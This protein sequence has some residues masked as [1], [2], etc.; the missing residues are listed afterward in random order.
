MDRLRL[1]T[2][3]LGQALGGAAGR[4][5]HRDRD[6]LGDQD[7][8]QRV[9]Q[10][11]LANAGAAGNDHHFGDECGPERCL[12]AVG[13]RQPVGLALAAD[14]ASQPVG[15][16]RDQLNR[17]GAIG[18][19]DAHRARGAD[20]VA[21][22]EQHDLADHLLL[23]PAPDDPLGTLRA[24]PG[25]LTQAARFLLD[26]VEHGFAEGANQLPRVDRPDTADHAGAEIFLDPLDRGRRRGFEERRPELDAA[27][28]IVDPGP[29][30]L[31]ELTGRGHRSMAK[32]GDQVA[33]AA[34]FYL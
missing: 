22:Q 15:V 29:A 21:V 8:E 9:D 27:R 19:V 28:A 5:A 26:D 30:R 23:G 11:G 6:R 32:D 24:D 18:L 16:L 2:G 10:R 17:I 20:A 34:G 1:E 4:G 31:H 25:H 13:K 33:L 7:L 12:L 3:A 14:V